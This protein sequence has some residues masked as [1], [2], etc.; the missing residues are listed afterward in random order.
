MNQKDLFNS[1]NKTTMDLDFLHNPPPV[2]W[3]LFLMEEVG[4]RPERQAR[5]LFIC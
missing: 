4:P 1:S 2:Y 5:D 3:K